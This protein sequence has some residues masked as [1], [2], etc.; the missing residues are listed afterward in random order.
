MLNNIPISFTYIPHVYLPVLSQM[1]KF[2][3]KHT[4][5]I[6][7]DGIWIQANQRSLVLVTIS[8][9]LV[10]PKVHA[11]QRASDASRVAICI[12][13]S[14]LPCRDMRKVMKANFK[15]LWNKKV[16]PVYSYYIRVHTSTYSIRLQL[17][18]GAAKRPADKSQ[19]LENQRSWSL[20]QF[21]M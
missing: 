13:P 21:T 5:T 14:I 19:A 3:R 10:Q 9:M 7:N 4:K 6:F 17:C 16:K 12:N 2:P 20:Q 18:V 8:R 1:G 15:L 11:S